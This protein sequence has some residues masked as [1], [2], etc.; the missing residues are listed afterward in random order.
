MLWSRQDPSSHN[1]GHLGYVIC[2]SFNALES[3]GP[4]K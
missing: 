3:Y 4:Y 2:K 1:G